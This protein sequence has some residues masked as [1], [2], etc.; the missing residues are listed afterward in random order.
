MNAPVSPAVLLS[1]VRWERDKRR[2]ET[3]LY[4]FVRQ[5]WHVME[6]GIA[7]VPSWHIEVICEH[8]QAIHE[9]EIRRL[10][11]NIPPRHS[12]STIVS[13]AFPCWEWI[14]S[15]QE[16][17]LCASY[18]GTLAIRDNLKARRLVTSPW[19]QE[20]WGDVFRMSGDQ[21]A[22]QRFENDKTGYRIATSVGGTATGEGGSRLILDDGISTQ[23]AQSDAVRNS[24]LEWLDMAWSTRLNN[25]KRDA[26]IEVAQRCHEKDPSGHRLK[27]G[28]W[29]HVCIPAE[30]DG[31]KRASSIF[32]EGY[33]PRT[34][35][36]QLICPERFGKKEI[37]D[38]K[39]QLGE[40]GVAGQLQ[41]RPAPA[42]GGILRSKHF[43][44]WPAKWKLPAFDFIVQSYDGAYDDDATSDND[45]TACTV[46]GVF[47]ER[48]L[49]G[50]I[51]LDAWDEHLGYPD[52]RKKV[53]E[54]WH[55]LYGKNEER[56]GKKADVVLVENKS[57]G[58]SII[59]DLR[60][61]NV[62]VVPYN[63]G[64]MSKVARA[65]AISAVHEL[66]IIYILES[67]KEPGKF[68]RW[69]RPFIEQ[70][71]SFPNAEHD[72]YV[73][74]YTQAMTFLRDGGYFE[75]PEAPLDEIEEYDYTK[76]KNVNPYGC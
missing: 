48:G 71:E 5:S 63:P 55:A 43:Q 46:W 38:L 51:L 75:M 68:I 3:S 52:F 21:S 72:D 6:P 20:R 57:S 69:A 26:M 15:P 58:I 33:D 24:T 36:G 40:Y 35:V 64:K 49:K 56:K 7:F 67:S 65:H 66:N 13:V 60:K 17:F 61:A 62:P 74:T 47:E 25:P 10:L 32:V 53:L 9:G 19:Y 45:P 73:D 22:K 41:Q 29:E 8:L 1:A 76:K 28:G 34:E 14:H 59:Q 30:Y 11:I 70:T 18:S 23:D 54:D 42:G 50:A 16:K 31:V 4:E 37:E 12:K 39:T 2:A 44:L 27:Q